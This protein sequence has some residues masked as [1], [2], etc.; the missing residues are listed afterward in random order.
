MSF[1][2][3]PLVALFLVLLALITSCSLLPLRRLASYLSTGST[4]GGG[5]PETGVYHPENPFIGW[6]IPGGNWAYVTA[7]YCDP[8]YLQQFGT[9]H[10]GIDLGYPQGTLVVSSATT[11]VTRAEWGHPMRGN[12]VETCAETGWCAIYMHLE[13]IFVLVDQVVE[14]GFPLGTVGSTGNS[15]GPHLHFEVHNP[16]GEAVDPAPSLP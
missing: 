3:R 10:W 15:T 5:C 9:I 12:N 4:G 14:M 8:Y 13:E 16:A 6:P 7:S 1:F 2:T 11:T